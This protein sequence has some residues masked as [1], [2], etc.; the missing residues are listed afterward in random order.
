MPDMNKIHTSADVVTRRGFFGSL[1]AFSLLTGCRP[2]D[3]AAFD[4]PD[5]SFGVISDV[6]LKDPGDEDT[7]GQAFEY[8][9]GRGVDGVLVA[10]DIADRGRISELKR[11]ADAWKSVFPGDKGLGGRHVEK[12]FVYGNHDIWGMHR[13]IKDDPEL[14]RKEAIGLDEKRIAQVWEELFDEPYSDFWIKH[15]KGYA[16]VGA[17]WTK[18]DQFDGLGDFL[19]AH[20]K[21]LD[22][23]K[24]FFYTQHSHPGGT[25]IGP[26]VWG[27]D[28]GASTRALSNYPNAVAF[29]GHSHTPLT[30]ER[31]VWQGAFTSVNTSSLRYCTS[32][33]PLRE[34]GW[35]N[36][37]GFKGD[38]RK[39][40]MEPL[41]DAGTRQGMLVSVYGGELAIERRD[42][43]SG[44]PLGPDWLVSVPA[45]GDRSF[46]A[47]AAERT[48]P[49][50]APDARLAVKTEG[51]LLRL[52]FP[53]ARTVANCRV[54]EYEVT[55]TLVEDGVDIVQ[56]QRRVL[57]PDF[58]R[59]ESSSGAPGCCVLSPAE[60]PVKGHT[61]FSVR[62]LD[63]FGLKG[64]PIAAEF[65]TSKLI[66]K[67]EE[68][69]A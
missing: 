56:V 11:F 9:R 51:R 19:K 64:E 68:K 46:A 41:R 40:L 32:L 22:P 63:C 58:A 47:R 14:A 29:S 55:A 45:R 43:V 30:D 5:L 42:F 33:Y 61:V 26:W 36:D 35:K 48:P 8:F 38:R 13:L 39:R 60:I 69:Q 16:F 6:H 44:L 1:G 31:S 27:H 10:G 17:H 24:P 49:Q 15:V 12:L 20:A 37:F 54:F 18:K 65:D 57:A 62:P 53:A 4:E 3:R 25:C 59:A 50:F 28:N 34:N 2:G 67:L 7:I 66:P 52:D 23:A 21:E